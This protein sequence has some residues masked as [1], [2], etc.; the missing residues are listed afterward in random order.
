MH[1]HEND[2]ENS[3][4]YIGGIGTVYIPVS[5]FWKS[6]KWYEEVLSLTW[7]GHCFKFGNNQPTL[8]LVETKNHEKP[9]L[10]FLSKDN[11][12]M[13]VLTLKIQRQELFEEFYHRLVK[14]G[15]QVEEI[16]ERGLCGDNFRVYDLDGNKIDIWNTNYQH[17]SD[18]VWQ[19]DK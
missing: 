18:P 4:S 5:D 2:H 19:E 16:E 1:N 15:V 3:K 7:G 12:E 10:N 13:F 6:K 14:M 8:F 11:Y 17:E 9:H